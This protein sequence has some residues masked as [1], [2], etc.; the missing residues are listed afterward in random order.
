M[1]QTNEN[2]TDQKVTS[3][4]LAA[5]VGFE[6]DD[7]K[8]GGAVVTGAAPFDGDEEGV[9]DDPRSIPSTRPQWS[10]PFNKALLV[11]GGTS[12]VVFAAY[13]FLDNL[14]TMP[15]RRVEKQV[16]QEFPAPDIDEP[17]KNETGKLKAEVALGEQAHAFEK[18]KKRGRNKP[19][20]KEKSASKSRSPAPSSVPKERAHPPVHYVAR[21]A[22][23]TIPVRQRRP[24]AL[25]V[26]QVER[27]ERSAAKPPQ[28]KP[29]QDP[30]V[31][32]LAAITAGSYGQ[33]VNVAA[34][35]IDKSG[36]LQETRDE[37]TIASESV[38][39]EEES[40]SL[41]IETESPVEYTSF[42]KNNQKS[43]VPFKRRGAYANQAERS[44]PMINYEDEAPILLEKPRK[45]ISAEAAAPA[46]LSS[47]L[48]F[49][50][51]QATMLGSERY[52][53][54]LTEP[55]VGT[56]NV[57]ILPAGTQLVSKLQSVSESGTVDLVPIK[58]FVP[59]NGGFEEFPFQEG[60]FVVR[61]QGGMPL[62]AKERRERK[63]RS[64]RT[65]DQLATFAVEEVTG[66]QGGFVEE[67][68][69][70][71]VRSL[72]D[73]DNRGVRNASGGRGVFYLSRGTKVEVSLKEPVALSVPPSAVE[74]ELV[75]PTPEH[76]LPLYSTDNRF[77]IPNAW[78]VPES[79]SEHYN[80]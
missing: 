58:A 11:L 78:Q 44:A 67:G 73:G 49:D 30:N 36:L 35:T 48:Y 1:N 59:Q 20:A 14:F 9:R 61:A 39:A 8:P 33:V 65:L 38:V 13:L 60:M 31:M 41:P 16:L 76:K 21:K 52:T 17:E 79:A 45:I 18:I 69:N 7:K 24:I 28:R 15:T 3:S 46:V 77:K 6:E 70:I 54:I 56:D 42:E 25:P 57:E 47:P 23:S 26:S 68:S 62:I 55:I 64:S 50:Q 29:D 72:R 75:E 10:R 74:T 63:S 2:E 19:A 22:I 12:A 66:G 51:G 4:R 27:K 34:S 53:V 40:D 37:H 43:E 80:Y 32:R 5:L 71:L